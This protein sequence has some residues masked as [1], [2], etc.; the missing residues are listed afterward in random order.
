MNGSTNELRSEYIHGSTNECEVIRCSSDRC[1][2]P[3]SPERLHPAA[4]RLRVR[5]LR[6]GGAAAAAR[7]QR[8]GGDQVGLPA[9]APGRPVRPGA[10]HPPAAQ[11]QRAPRRLHQGQWPAHKLSLLPTGGNRGRGV[12]SLAT[13]PAGLQ[14][15]ISRHLQKARNRTEC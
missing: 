6:G 3:L 5:Q 11:V 7:R 10:H 1:L 9:A 8:G 12:E 14:N 4:D 15:A 2:P 13:D